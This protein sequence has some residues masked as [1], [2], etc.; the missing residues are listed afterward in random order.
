MS[1][2]EAIARH[3]RKHWARYMLEHAR[4]SKYKPNN[5]S[6]EIIGLVSA[7]F[8]HLT[9]DAVPGSLTLTTFDTDSRADSAQ[10]LLTNST[11]VSRVI[12][13]AWIRGKPVT[14]LSDGR[15]TR[16]EG[17][18]A[19]SGKGVASGARGGFLHDKFVD[20]ES[21]AKNGEQTFETGNNFVVTA[22]QVNKLADYYW[23]L[24]KTPKHIYTLSLTGFQSWY[25]PGEWYTLQIGGAGGAEY[26]D[27]TVECFDVRCSLA[28]GGAPSTS[29]AFR[30]VE[31]NWKFDSND[32]ARQI[33]SG[34][35]SRRPNQNVVTVA[36]QYYSG[37]ADYYCDGTE[38][39]TEINNAATYLSQV[40][41]GIIHLSKGDFNI[42]SSI[43]LTSGIHLEGEGEASNITPATS[44]NDIIY[45]S[46][47]TSVTITG[48]SLTNGSIFL[49]DCISAVVDNCRLFGAANIYNADGCDD[50]IISNNIID[51][52]GVSAGGLFAYGAISLCGERVIIKNN[53]I[54]NI[55]ETSYVRGIDI[56]G[57]YGI[58]EGNQINALTS[59]GANKTYGISANFSDYS[60]VSHNRIQECKNPSTATNVIGLYI[61]T[62][63]TSVKVC[64]N[65]CYNNGS[66]T[67]VGNANSNNFFDGGTDTQWAG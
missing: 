20:Y 51:G 58:I 30:E 29:I 49:N 22:A 8:T 38:D 65:Y 18:V 60:I 1:I 9:T 63:T 4:E 6:I 13:A 44:G 42:T 50:S 36:A 23:K 52:L 46:S 61:V 43:T 64:S 57:N 40:G 5:K 27:S 67:G 54:R 15:G 17:G 33:A 10:I 34:S 14:R 31:E 59:R 47:T 21:I 25:E 39:Q 35:F 45:C 3:E 48:L 37:Y 32:V 66:D 53:I 11:G 26:I 28:V 41:G 56:T 7:T 19:S 24:N 62:G 12:I 16:A 55:D 2:R